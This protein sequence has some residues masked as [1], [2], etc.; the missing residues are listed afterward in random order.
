MTR[1][2][3]DV[4]N[5]MWE[6]AAEL[7]ELFVLSIARGWLGIPA[8]EQRL[9]EL[10][11]DVA[12]ASAAPARARRRARIAQAVCPRCTN[13]TFMV[14]LPHLRAWQCTMHGA[15]PV[16]FTDDLMETDYPEHVFWGEDWSTGS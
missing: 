2:G 13:R 6:A 12:M 7:G 3:R 8:L 14:R 5:T 11:R 16:T 1:T 4:W 10:E 9:A 15:L